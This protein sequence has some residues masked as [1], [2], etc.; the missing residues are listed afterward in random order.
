VRREAHAGSPASSAR[1]SPDS[2]PNSETN[3][4]VNASAGALDI[5][6]AHIRYAAQLNPGNVALP[7]N[8][9]GNIFWRGFTSSLATN[10]ILVNSTNTPA[11]APPVIRLLNSFNLKQ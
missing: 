7:A 10:E 2:T 6:N 8:L 9:Y 3:Q 1:S 4:W 11:T 5:P